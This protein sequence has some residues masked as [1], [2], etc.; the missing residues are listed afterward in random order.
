MRGAEGV[1]NVL[2]MEEMHTIF[3][4][5]AGAVTKLVR[6]SDENSGKRFIE[7]LFEPKYPY[8]YLA[9]ERN[10]EL[11]KRTAAYDKFF[12]FEN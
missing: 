5:G 4:V 11:A 3:A 7:R 10:A 9:T 1:Y 6:Q 2:M 12:G 8:E